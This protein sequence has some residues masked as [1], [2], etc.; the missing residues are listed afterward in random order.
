MSNYKSLSDSELINSR[1]YSRYLPS[2]L[3]TE[4]GEVRAAAVGSW[5]LTS[6]VT[7]KQLWAKS[8]KQPRH[9]QSS[10]VPR[11][12]PHTR[13]GR[14]GETTWEWGGTEPQNASLPAT[15]TARWRSLSKW[16]VWKGGALLTLQAFSLGNR[17][18]P[19]LKI[20][21]PLPL[22]SA[23]SWRFGL[24]S[25]S[26]LHS[27]SLIN[28]VRTSLN[29]RSHLLLW[30]HVSS[31]SPHLNDSVGHSVG[32]VDGTSETLSGLW[33]F[34]LTEQLLAFKKIGLSSSAKGKN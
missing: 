10:W 12:L 19:L 21:F 23:L 5:T 3:F 33:D 1:L 27:L 32:D 24:W 6:T 18:T 2:H 31:R 4:I 30:L 11:L 7:K 14:L 34:P 26:S 22:S 13:G 25:F 15:R 28:K 17:W 16:L 9:L 8:I 20:T 29:A